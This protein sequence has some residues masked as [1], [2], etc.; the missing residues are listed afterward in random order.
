MKV[1][2]KMRKNI[3]PVNGD[4]E[5]NIN[6]TELKDWMQHLL[7]VVEQSEFVYLYWVADVLSQ[8]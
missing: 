1:L 4:K 6:M 8:I 2:V 5:I 3:T 7:L